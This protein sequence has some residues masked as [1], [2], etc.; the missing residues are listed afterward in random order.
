MDPKQKCL[1]INDEIPKAKLFESEKREVHPD[2]NTSW[3]ISPEPFWVTEA[4][5][6]WFEALGPHLLNFYR[7]C[8]LLYSQSVRGIQPAWVAE[9]LEIGKPETVIQYGRMNRFKTQLPGVLRPD[10][11]PMADGMAITELDSIPGFIGATGCLSRL[12]AELGYAI[13]GGDNGMVNGY[14]DMI[15]ALAKKDEPTL[16]IVVSDESE[17]YWAEMVWLA[18]ALC[19]VGVKA[20]TV[21]PHDIIFSEDGLLVEHGDDKRPVDVL[22]RFYELFDL[23]NI[24]KSELMFYS[25]KKRTVVMTPPPKSYLE[26]KLCLALF[27]HRTL[28]PFWKR[29]L[30]KRTYAFLQGV[31]PETWIIDARPLPPHAVI[32]GLA[33]EDAAVTDWR[34]LGTLTQKQ[35]E[36]VIK[37]SGFSELAWGSRGVAIGHDLPTE[38]WETVIEDSL[39]NFEKTPHV[40]QRFHTARRV[41]MQYYDFDAGDMQEM[42]C[43]PLLRPYYFVAGDTV[44]LGGMQA[45]VCPADKKILHGMVDSIIVPCAQMEEK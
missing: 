18:D 37:P 21:K 36:L 3:R 8:N 14:A 34:Q 7:A 38:A 11:L 43:R 2:C 4:E 25:A 41:R 35:R 16:A 40:L 17:D 9:Y 20:F 13:I 5:L 22:Y 28:Q 33:V 45:A 30:G 31:I 39:D 15:R 32:P 26:E 42:A 19:E 23:P 27:H 12:Y 44:K 1:F 10:I 29:Q 24:P 6:K